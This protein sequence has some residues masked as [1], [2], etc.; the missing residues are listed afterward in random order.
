MGTLFSYNLTLLITS[1]KCP[2]VATGF[3]GF[4]DPD[5]SHGDHDIVGLVLEM[6]MRVTSRA[7]VRLML[8]KYRRV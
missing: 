6:D 7:F 8:K 1:K 2:C 4:F 5:V 3:T